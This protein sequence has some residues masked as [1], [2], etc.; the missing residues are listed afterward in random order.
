MDCIAAAARPPL[1]LLLMRDL[2]LI[3][4]SKS[5]R[6]RHRRFCRLAIH[7][8]L[9]ADGQQHIPLGWTFVLVHKPNA[10]VLNLCCS[11]CAIFE[12]S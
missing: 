8:I 6:S 7:R 9:V 3:L 1:V 11:I 10:D 5:L 12:I 2:L 4:S